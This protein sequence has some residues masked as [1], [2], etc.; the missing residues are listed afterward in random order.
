MKKVD[1]LISDECWFQSKNYGRGHKSAS[2]VASASG[3]IY[4]KLGMSHYI[5]Y[6]YMIAE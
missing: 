1:K 2:S 5:P 4:P 3:N 6:G